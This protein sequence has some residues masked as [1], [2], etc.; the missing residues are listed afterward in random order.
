MDLNGLIINSIDEWPVMTFCGDQHLIQ[1]DGLPRIMKY[2]HTMVMMNVPVMMDASLNA[3][4][5]P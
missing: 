2:K 1:L 5:K 4:L 3:V